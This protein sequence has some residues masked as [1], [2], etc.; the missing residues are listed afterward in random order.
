MHPTSPTASARA[1]LDADRAHADPAIWIT[2][3]PDEAV[4]AR[5]AALEAEGP[6][7]RPLWGVPFA[8]KDN[9]DVAGLPTTAACPAYATT[10][11]ESAPA[12]QRLLDAGA[13][14]LGKTNL[15]QFATGLVGVRSPYGVPRN[16]FDP[17]RVPGGS[18]SGSGCVVAA[19]IVPFALG[20][21]T[22]GS[23]RVPAMFGNVV[24]LKPTIGSISARGMVPA[25]RSIDTISV[26]ARTVDE[27]LAAARVMAGWDEADPYSRAA[28]HAFLRR[29]PAATLRVASVAPDGCTPEQARLY[30]AAAARLGAEPVSIAPLLAVA[31]LL[32]DGPWVAERTAALRPMLDKPDDLHPVTRAIL[33]GGLD[34]RTVDAFDA[35]HQLALARR[36]A[37]ALFRTYDAL[38]LPTAPNTPTLAELDAD[39]I[40]PNSRLGTWTNFVNLCDLAAWAVPSGIGADGLPGGVTLVGPAWSEGRLA[41]AADRLHRA[42]AQTVG[43]TTMTLP[44][45][46]APDPAGPDETALF[47]VGGHMAGLPL[48]GELTSRGG[49]FVAH[50]RTQPQYRLYA[51]GNR[52]GLL[53][54]PGGAAIAGEIWAV[55]T[56]AIGALLAGVPR[57]L[58]FGTVLLESGPCLGFLAEA[59]GVAGA[60]DITHHGGWRAYLAASDPLAGFIQAGST[61]MRLPIDPAWQ[62]GVA[63]NLR[64]ILA[65]AAMLGDPALPDA[66]DPAPI[67]RA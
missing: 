4:L 9:I 49:R 5:A 16:V 37:Q 33:Q 44:H 67:F 14:L 65:Q 45:A 30:H 35:F 20:T 19:G 52:P 55:P 18:S 62:D 54:A 3:L 10:P 26:F 34:R 36:F 32:Y 38:L 28:P 61:L 25:C 1:A 29:S 2:R 51:L 50:A 41:D 12:V 39:P 11:T 58:G 6:L 23:G 22:A 15:D 47:C 66:T 53:A 46:E 43:N 21:D 60:P 40:G 31:R 48:N 42:A 57:P 63:F 56:A 8:V 64:T 24:G 27:A 7:D 13:V 59:E 17:M